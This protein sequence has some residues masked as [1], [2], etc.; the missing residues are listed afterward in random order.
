MGDSALELRAG[1][2]RLAA[3][4]DLGGSLAG[5]WWRDMPVLRS[6]EPSALE[7]PRRSACFPLVP[8]SNRL[9]GRAFAWRGVHHTTLPNFDDSPHSLHGVGWLRAWE[10]TAATAATAH[11]RY[12]HRADGH[13]PFD[14]EAHQSIALTA[15]VLRLELRVVNT[16]PVEQPMG[17]GWHPYFPRRAR[18]RLRIDVETRWEHD[19]TQLPTHAVG[20]DGIDADVASLALD[21]CHSGWHAPAS[22]ADEQFSLRLDASA[23]LNHLV[24]FTPPGREHFC[25]EPVSHVNDAIHH[26][27]PRARGLVALAPGA[28]LAAWMTLEVQPR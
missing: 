17:L 28:S 22:I 27:D 7:G 9:G 15:E 3:R 6:C 18:S 4:P 2:L 21:H 26:A 23:D 11:L 10:T 14:F 1:D 20:I 8:Y 12:R 19:S 13:W 24:V 16:A 5:L 25:V